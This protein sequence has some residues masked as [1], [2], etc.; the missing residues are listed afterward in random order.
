[1]SPRSLTGKPVQTGLQLLTATLLWL[2]ATPLL[3][4]ELYG[5]RWEKAWRFTLDSNCPQQIREQVLARSELFSALVPL[6]YLDT[7]GGP[8]IATFNQNSHF[9]CS[10]DFSEQLQSLPAG[11]NYLSADLT[12]AQGDSVMGRAHLWWEDDEIIEV[13]IQLDPALAGWMLE[14][15]IDHEI[16]HGLGCDHSGEAAALLF[17]GIFYDKGTHFDDLQCLHSLYGL[18][19]SLLDYRGNLFIPDARVIGKPGSWWGVLKDGEL[20]ASGENQTEAEQ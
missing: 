13:D 1:M 8:G 5:P 4:F 15:V 2:A 16:L 7:M 11:V 12:S 14:D 18:Q 19:H 9:Y 20:I 10:T 6:E 3:G 17:P